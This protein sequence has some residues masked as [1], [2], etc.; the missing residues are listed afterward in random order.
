MFIAHSLTYRKLA[1]TSHLHADVVSIG[2]KHPLMKLVCITKQC[3][4]KT[5]TVSMRPFT[6]PFLLV[7]AYAH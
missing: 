4:L 7:D 1:R 5:Y 2:V 3:T 6:S